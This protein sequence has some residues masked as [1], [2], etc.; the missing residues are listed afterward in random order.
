MILGS[1]FPMLGLETPE[2]RCPSN[3]G[4]FTTTRSSHLDI[5]KADDSK[6]AAAA[7]AA[8]TDNASA[9]DVDRCQYP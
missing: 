9:S 6:A 7:V 3:V 2:L 1:N 5:A 8:D 4:T